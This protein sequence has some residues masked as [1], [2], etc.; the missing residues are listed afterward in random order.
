MVQAPKRAAPVGSPKIIRDKAFA[1][2][3]ETACESHKHAPS[4]RGQQVWVRTALGDKGVL[5][6][7]EAVRKWFAGEARPRPK[8]MSKLAQVLEVDEAW[9]SLGLSADVEPKLREARNAMA[10]G[11]VNVLAGFIQMNGG[12]PAFPDAAETDEDLT[13]IIRGK[14]Y[15]IHVAVGRIEDGEVRFVVP[16]EHSHL[17][18]VGVIQ[19]GSVRCDILRL[20]SE[21]IDKH[22]AKKKSTNI[23]VALRKDGTDYV[24][25]SDRWPKITNLA[26]RL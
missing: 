20:P 3:L 23:E 19:T 5:V 6:S 18:V 10:D 11:A 15:I 4:G 25:G 26:E 8:I 9:L 21:L 17:T 14:R 12:H 16:R 7:P 24:S 13:A 2:R 22:G 1:H